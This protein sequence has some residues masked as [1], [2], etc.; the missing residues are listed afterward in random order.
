[1]FGIRAA[2]Y[3]EITLKDG[4]IEQANFDAYQIL[5][6]NKARRYFNGFYWHYQSVTHQRGLNA[7]L[8]MG[9]SRH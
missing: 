7:T 2:L 3:G 9:V 1:M 4:R 8:G 5:C 6:M